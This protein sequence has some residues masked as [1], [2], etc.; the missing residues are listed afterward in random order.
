MIQVDADVEQAAR[1]LAALTQ[2]SVEQ[3]IGDAV[4]E[5]L[6]KAETRPPGPDDP[7]AYVAYWIARIQSLPPLPSDQDPTA[8]LYDENG[9]PA[10]GEATR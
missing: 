7:D 5:A 6:A 2:R 1:R 3:A 10:G 8:F 4:R 9:L